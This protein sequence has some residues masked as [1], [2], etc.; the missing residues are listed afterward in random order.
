[1]NV[2]QAKLKA[3]AGAK[4]AAALAGVAGKKVTNRLVEAGDAALMKLSEGAR[5]RKRTRT[6][7]RAGKVVLVTGA[8]AAT[9]LAGRAV[10]KRR[11]KS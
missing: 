10:M 6:L 2:K 1:M 8:A 9:L 4:V 7:K 11:G 5:K 3:K